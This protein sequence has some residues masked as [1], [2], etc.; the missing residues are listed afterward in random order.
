MDGGPRALNTRHRRPPDL[1]AYAVQDHL[2]AIFDKTKV[3]G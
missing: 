1:S 3:K 2:T